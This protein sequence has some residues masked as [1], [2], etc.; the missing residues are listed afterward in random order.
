MLAKILCR[1]G[2]HRRST[3]RSFRGSHG[4]MKSR[5]SRCGVPMARDDETGAWAAMT[6]QPDPIE[7]NAA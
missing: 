6:L 3:S 1:F 4:Q 7:A 5:C 2:H